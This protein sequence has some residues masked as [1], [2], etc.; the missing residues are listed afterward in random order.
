MLFSTVVPFS[1]SDQNFNLSFRKPNLY[2][3]AF[4]FLIYE[5]RTQL[6]LSSLTN[7]IGPTEGHR[8]CIREITLNRFIKHVSVIVKDCEIQVLPSH[9]HHLHHDV[10]VRD[11]D[12]AHSL[13]RLRNNLRTSHPPKQPWYHF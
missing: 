10:I 2:S 1:R 9:A 7:P 6:Y 3:V 12:R 11:A 8:S 13:R 5:V 4:V